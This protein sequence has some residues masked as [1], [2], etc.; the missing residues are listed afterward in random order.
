MTYEKV[1]ELRKQLAERTAELEELES[2]E[3]S[4]IWLNDLDAIELAL[5]ERDR[6]IKQAEEDE[7]EA[8]EKTAKRQATKSKKKAAPR[9][10]APPKKKAAA[11]KK[12]DEDS[13]EASIV[14]EKKVAKKTTRKPATK[15]A[16]KDDDDD[17]D[18]MEL[19]LFD[20][21]KLS[22]TVSTDSSESALSGSKRPSPKAS[23]P[24]KAT[25]AKRAKGPTKRRAKPKEIVIE[26]SDEEDF[27]CNSESEDDME[28]EVAKPA[29]RARRTTR[30]NAAPAKYNVV[31]SDDSF[32]MSSDDDSDF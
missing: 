11:L 28:I 9:K 2:T 20:R 26:S 32:A 18:D 21:L 1:E 31:D 14:P 27:V 12:V 25:R 29:P 5:D 17:D 19:S 24:K 7:K 3:P 23:S 4:Q 6:D 16:P 22:K 13:E 15:V 30:K 8:Q 10:R